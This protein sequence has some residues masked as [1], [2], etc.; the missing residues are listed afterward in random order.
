[1]NAR[2]R[3]YTDYRA[4]RAF[5]AFFR[6]TGLLAREGY[7]PPTLADLRWIDHT[8]LSGDALSRPGGLLIWHDYRM[9][10]DFGPVRLPA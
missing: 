1:M 2:A 10:W 7:Y 3:W 8:R 6:A 4:W 5:C 9:K